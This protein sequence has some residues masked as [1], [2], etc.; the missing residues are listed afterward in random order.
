MSGNVQGRGGR[1]RH[2]VLCGLIVPIEFDNG[3]RRV[4]PSGLDSDQGEETVPDGSGRPVQAV[5]LDLFQPGEQFQ[6]RDTGIVDVVVGPIPRERRDEKAR[7][8]GDGDPTLVVEDDIVQSHY[9]DS[10]TTI[11]EI[12]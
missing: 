6:K 12:T 11:V 2:I 7:L 8:F 10:S 5:P 3:H 9:R 4:R 1:D